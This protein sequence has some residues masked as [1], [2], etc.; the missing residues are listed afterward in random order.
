[1]A[2]RK[3]NGAVPAPKRGGVD[4]SN[5]NIPPSLCNCLVQCVERWQLS[6]PFK[7]PENEELW[8]AYYA[9]RAALEFRHEHFWEPDGKELRKVYP[10]PVVEVPAA[11]DAAWAAVV[12]QDAVLLDGTTLPPMRPHAL[13]SYA[14]GC[15]SSGT[16]KGEY[17][18]YRTRI[19]ERLEATVTA[20]SVG[21]ADELAARVASGLFV[22]NYWAN[23]E[24][25]GTDAD[26]R[27]VEFTTRL[28]SPS[29]NGASLDLHWYHHYRERM[30][31]APEKYST[32]HVFPRTLEDTNPTD[33][34]KSFDWRKDEGQP[35]ATLDGDRDEERVFKKFAATS[36]IRALRDVLFPP[37]TPAT[38]TEAPPRLLS[39]RKVFVLLA[40]ASGAHIIRGEAGWLFHGIRGR[41][42]LESG[43]E[44]DGQEDG[45]EDGPGCVVC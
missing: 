23:F 11:V 44:S 8:A 2:K 39:L 5:S 22:L 28:Y 24:E 21:G 6:A 20:S 42:K 34:T 27:T 43:E 26:V 9:E 38:A 3:T 25:T 13:E 10:S 35:I 30:T 7:S 12:V 41:F 40:R 16:P 19:R 18:D 32:L 14:A 37:P 15:H 36:K 4:D 17:T 31:T 1:M 45:P 33:P 29:G